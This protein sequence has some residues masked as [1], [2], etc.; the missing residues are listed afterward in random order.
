MAVLLVNADDFGM[1]GAVNEAIAKCVEF[2]TVN[3]LSVITNGAAPDYA[4]LK[5]LAQKRIYTGIHIAWVCE[6]W[7]TG[8]DFFY[9]W[10]NILPKFLRA[11]KKFR[12]QMQHEAEIQIIRMIENGFTPDHIDSHQHVHHLPGVWELML[13]L[14]EKYNIKR[15]R[16]AK[17]KNNST[18]RKNIPG[19]ILNTIA[20]GK[21]TGTLEFYCAGIKHAGN[22]NLPLFARELQACNGT[23]TELVVHPGTSNPILNQLYSRWGFNWEKEYHAL[24]SHDFM[25]HVK[26]NNFTLALKQV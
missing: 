2:G 26:E 20:S 17:A 18:L 9:D 3:S 21:S 8:N 5:Y 6:P 11:G 25:L 19:L 22:Y 24:L 1:H 14:K 13:E 10:P 23:D 7:I 4:L 16:V 12:L 15:I